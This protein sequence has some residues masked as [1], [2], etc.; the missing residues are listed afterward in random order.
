MSGV[1][2]LFFCSSC[3]CPIFVLHLCWAVLILISKSLTLCL[4]V[5]F[6]LERLWN[7]HANKIPRGMFS[8]PNSLKWLRRLGAHCTNEGSLWEKAP[9]DEPKTDKQQTNREAHLRLYPCQLAGFSQPWF[10][11]I[12][13]FLGKLRC[14]LIAI[15][16]AAPSACCAGCSNLAEPASPGCNYCQL[17]WD[18]LCERMPCYRTHRGKQN[19]DYL[20]CTVFPWI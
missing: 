8:S 5:S 7:L 2:I 9:H 15:G 14:L 20:I 4:K 11:R 19:T 16:Y 12:L 6:L 18:I 13:S 10:L 1:K 3:Y 17:H